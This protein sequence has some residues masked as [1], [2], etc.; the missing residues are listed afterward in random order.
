MISVP[1]IFRSTEAGEV[2]FVGSMAL[3]YTEC[4]SDAMLFF[5]DLDA[6]EESAL[7]M[8]NTVQRCTGKGMRG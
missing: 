6:M 5:R 4:R 2:F 7:C 1:I 8:I 3:F